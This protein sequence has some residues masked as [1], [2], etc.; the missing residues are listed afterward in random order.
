[1]SQEEQENGAKEKSEG[2]QTK[3]YSID[4]YP[5]Q[6]VEAIQRT[7][8]TTLAVA[9]MRGFTDVKITGIRKIADDVYAVRFTY[10]T[11]NIVER[12]TGKVTEQTF[13][14]GQGLYIHQFAPALYLDAYAIANF[15]QDVFKPPLEP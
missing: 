5:P 1:M 13:S 8:F 12:V 14:E 11:L 9:S 3:Q 4:Q 7:T 2:E 6:L 15:V 10:Y